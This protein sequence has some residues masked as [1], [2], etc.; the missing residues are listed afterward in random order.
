MDDDD[1][2]NKLE[3][4]GL[5]E[6]CD[7]VQDDWKTLPFA[8]KVP[9]SST[10]QPFVS[11][12]STG[13]VLLSVENND[14]QQGLVGMITFLQ[15]SVLVWVS[16]GEVTEAGEIADS[17]NSSS[18]GQVVGSAKALSM[19]PFIVGVPRKQFQGAFVDGQQT[20]GASSKLVGCDRNEDEL[21][22]QFMAE[23]LSQ[24]LGSSVFVSCHLQGK[25]P[26]SMADDSAD[27]ALMKVAAYAERELYRLLKS[28]IR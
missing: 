5:V 20:N 28:E 7:S 22:A 1:R 24:K 9:R 6:V 21:I 19:G 10:A 2:R 3:A 4:K 15:K 11:E 12:F 23:R 27:A 18:M 13:P 16:W 25:I 26:V 17:N 8:I 14:N